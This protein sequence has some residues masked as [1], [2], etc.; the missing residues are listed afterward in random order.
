MA[1]LTADVEAIKNANTQPHK[2]VTLNLTRGGTEASNHSLN[3]PVTYAQAAA[4]PNNHD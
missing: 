3:K 2:Q 4:K 1:K